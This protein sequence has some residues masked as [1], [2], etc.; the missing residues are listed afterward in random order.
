MKCLKCTYRR[1]ELHMSPIKLL[2]HKTLTRQDTHWKSIAATSLVTGLQGD[3]DDDD[4]GG[5]G[6]CGCGCG[7]SYAVSLSTSRR[8]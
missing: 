5:G 7:G 1:M 3:D 8:F 2:K 6:G 4:G